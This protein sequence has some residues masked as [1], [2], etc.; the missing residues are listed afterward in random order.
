M[1]ILAGYSKQNIISIIDC[2]V[3]FILA[4]GAK[5]FLCCIDTGWW[6]SE[7]NSSKRLSIPAGWATRWDLWGQEE[8]D[9]LTPGLISACYLKD[10]AFGCRWKQDGLT[11][12]SE[13]RVAEAFAR[14]YLEM[15]R[16]Y[17]TT[18]Q[19][20]IHWVAAGIGGGDV[21]TSLVKWI[22]IPFT[23]YV[24]FM[25]ELTPSEMM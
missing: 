4:K 12:E 15:P 19:C 18:T 5:I 2:T 1:G 13:T 22:P 7:R 17:D 8:E 9:K 24:L 10:Y 21:K 11:P 16:S 3:S 20:W 6:V 23:V 25:A 14:V